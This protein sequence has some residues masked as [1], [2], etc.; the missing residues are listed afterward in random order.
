MQFPLSMKLAL[1]FLLFVVV[2][3]QLNGHSA[4][5]QYW[6]AFFAAPSFEFLWGTDSLGRDVLSRAA[7]GVH[8]ALVVAVGVLV[9]TALIGIPLGLLAA[10]YGGW[11]EQVLTRV[12]D[13]FLAIPGFLLA[14]LVTSLLGPGLINVI[15]ALAIA[16]WITFYRLTRIETLKLQQQE[17][18][19]AAKV[20]GQSPW[21][22]VWQH[23]LPNMAPVLLVEA[24]FVAGGAILAEAGLSFL[25][26]GL[27][28]PEA[29]LGQ[30]LREGSRYMLVAPH[31]VV[32]PA[33]VLVALL[34]IFSQLGETL[35]RN[36]TPQGEGN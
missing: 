2:I 35:R 11:V 10:W 5:W 18:V 12:S 4:Q 27:P 19:Q 23:L 7:A 9:L 14:V 1:G 13:A 33:L 25:G 32:A 36:L 31:L 17:F 34:L 8:V 29:S 24:I 30:M 28:L 6:D 22:I 3:A 21:H 15:A 20:L 26:I 16:G